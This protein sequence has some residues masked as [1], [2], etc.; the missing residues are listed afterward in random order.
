MEWIAALGRFALDILRSLGHHAA[1]FWE[2]LRTLPVI[3][4]R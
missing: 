2:L 1:F 4:T 3:S